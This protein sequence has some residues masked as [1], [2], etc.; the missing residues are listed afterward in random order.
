MTMTRRLAIPFAI[1]VLLGG[2]ALWWYSSTQV[3][4]RQTHQ[5]LSTLTL[6]AGSGSAGRQ[7]G[8]YRLSAL[9]APEVEFQTP[10][11]DE[12]NG[13]FDRSEVESAY[14][15]LC[16]QTKESYFKLLDFHSINI[17][18]DQAEVAFALEA[19]V[20]LPSLRLADGRYEA[21]FY[22]QIHDHAWQLT[23]ASWVKAP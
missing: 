11:L 1:L 17:N 2:F 19:L 3:L 20:Q 12:A 9:L 6:E 4:K 14:S 21:T 16:E 10:T 18:G 22:W 15:W 5:I 13:S 8:V 23:R 7:L